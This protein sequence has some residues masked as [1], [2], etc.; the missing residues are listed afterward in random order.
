MGESIDC[1]FYLT[2]IYS[3]YYILSTLPQDLVSVVPGPVGQYLFI[4]W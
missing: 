4:P 3:G 2:S 1:T